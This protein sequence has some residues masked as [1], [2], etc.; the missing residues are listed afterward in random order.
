MNGLARG[1]AS[2]AAWLLSTL[3]AAGLALI[4]FRYIGGDPAVA[5]PELRPS[6]AVRMLLFALHA[7][8]AGIA[9]LLLPLQA[10]LARTSRTGAAHR[11]IGRLYVSGVTLGAAAALPLSLHS[12]GG[13]VAGLGFAA[14]ALAW[15]GCTWAGVAAARGGRRRA[16]AQWMVRSGA[17]T[18]SAITLRLYLP[19]PELV[20]L[21][22]EEGYRWIAWG[23]WLPNLFVAQWALRCRA[24]SEAQRTAVAVPFT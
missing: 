6:A 9:L 5:P 11:W 15:L 4:S 1:T 13:P 10:M 20:G 8:G 23:C 12:F 7:V 16:H 22:Y 17:L 21:A 2:G 18:A 3:L 24:R 14:L 19:L